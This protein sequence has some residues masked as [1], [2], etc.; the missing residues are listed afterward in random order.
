M[1]TLLD[2]DEFAERLEKLQP[3]PTQLTTEHQAQIQALTTPVEIPA[4]LA[5][6]DNTAIQENDVLQAPRGGKWLDVK[7]LEVL[8]DGQVKVRWIGFGPEFDDVMPRSRLRS[9]SGR[10]TV[11]G[12]HAF[13][14]RRKEE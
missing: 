11:I 9:P 5:V 3:E 4:E 6:T 8:A 2:G 7:V 12:S 10:M 14:V 1:C 13:P